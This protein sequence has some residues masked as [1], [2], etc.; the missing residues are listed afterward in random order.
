MG[1]LLLSLKLVSKQASRIRQ[2]APHIVEEA[3]AAGARRIVAL[4][5]EEPQFAARIDPAHRCSATTRSPVHKGLVETEF[6]AIDTI[7]STGRRT[8]D[9]CPSAELPESGG[10]RVNPH[11]VQEAVAVS[12]VRVEAPATEQPE[13]TRVVG[14]GRCTPTRTRRDARSN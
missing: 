2:V 9:P 1:R 5:T 8:L 14:P 3:V 7:L 12:A 4:T 6:V 11:I 10:R 13:V